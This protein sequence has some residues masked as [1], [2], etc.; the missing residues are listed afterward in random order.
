MKVGVESSS[1]PPPVEMDL[2]SSIHLPDIQKSTLSAEPRSKILVLE[3]S[4]IH[5]YAA[6]QKW[7]HGIFDNFWAGHSLRH[8][9]KSYQVVRWVSL[10]RIL[11]CT[12]IQIPTYCRYSTIHFS[13][14][15][16][17]SRHGDTK[18]RTMPFS[19]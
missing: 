2:S 4:V 10:N 18:S 1:S 13:L 7:R 8:F 19:S 3:S 15:S 14:F 17:A 16:L 6:R 5:T 9:A 11:W 12:C